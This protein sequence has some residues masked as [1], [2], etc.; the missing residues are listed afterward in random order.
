MT[1]NRFIH[2][3]QWVVGHAHLALLGA[4]GFIAT[5]T[6]YYMI[7]QILRRPL[8]SRNLADAQYWLFLVGITGFFWSLTIAGLA[9]GTAWTILGQQVV[10]AYPVVKPYFLLRSAFGSLIYIG[11]IFELINIYMTLRITDIDRISAERRKQAEDLTELMP[12]SSGAKRS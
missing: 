2:Y 9:Q 6:V 10:R 7:P 12:L 11:V 8:W 5:G 1:V 3:T 4:F